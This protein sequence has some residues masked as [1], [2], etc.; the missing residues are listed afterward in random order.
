VEPEG[1]TSEQLTPEEGRKRRKTAG[2]KPLEYGGVSEKRISNLFR[3]NSRETKIS[4]G[5]GSPGSPRN[6]DT[7]VLRA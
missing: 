5:G 6:C 1:R 4:G 7:K 3:E 2:F